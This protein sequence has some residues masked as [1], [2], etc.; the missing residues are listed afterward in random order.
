MAVVL[1]LVTEES[2]KVTDFAGG[3]LDPDIKYVVATNGK[4]HEY[5][6][7]ILK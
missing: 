5:L 2:G 4:I 6:L 3:D 1:L 7:G